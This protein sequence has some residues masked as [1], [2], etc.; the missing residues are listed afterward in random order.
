MKKRFTKG[1]IALLA[2]IALIAVGS[3]GS[4]RAAL[5]IQ[6][7]DMIVALQLNH[8]GVDLYENGEHVGL[9][10]DTGELLAYMNGKVE[11]GRV[12]KEEIAAKNERDKDI[13]VR[14][15]IQK[16]W[17]DESGKKV[18]NL[19][20]DEIKLVYGSEDYN[21]GAWQ[22]NPLE[23][24]AESETYYLTNVLGSGAMSDPLF[25]RV[26]IDG[27]ATWDVNVTENPDGTTT[28][29]QT[30]SSKYD[31]YYFN[32]KATVQAIQ[33]HNATDAIQS[34]WGVFNVTTGGNG[35]PLTVG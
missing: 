4:V 20:P 8:L 1:A 30:Q 21:T 2:A 11:L 9:K 18:Q 14:M 5:D 13:Y 19:S 22:I 10:N 35:A 33:T 27:E 16:Y 7:N 26:S 31:G 15:I 17:T 23:S 3:I 25:N 12:Y 29:V 28:T 24:T 32:I 34:Q 6:S